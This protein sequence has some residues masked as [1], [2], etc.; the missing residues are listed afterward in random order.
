M[1]NTERTN[2]V[3]NSCTD[4]GLKEAIIYLLQKDSESNSISQL[5]I[6]NSK[7]NNTSEEVEKG[8]VWLKFTSKSSLKMLAYKGTGDIND[9]TNYQDIGGFEMDLLDV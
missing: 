4:S 6:K 2:L 5:R 8:D 3:K 9:E 1:N 7:R